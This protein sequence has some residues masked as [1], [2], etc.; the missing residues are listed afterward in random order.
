MRKMTQEEEQKAW[1]NLNVK[2]LKNAVKELGHIR[3]YQF[4]K[5]DKDAFIDAVKILDGLVEKYDEEE[6]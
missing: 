3:L 1:L 2:K 6:A 5:D 4:E